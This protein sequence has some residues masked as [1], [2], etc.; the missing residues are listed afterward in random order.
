[1]PAMLTWQVFS[2]SLDNLA[3]IYNLSKLYVAQPNMQ[4]LKT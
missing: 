2:Q 3:V 1:M 4:K